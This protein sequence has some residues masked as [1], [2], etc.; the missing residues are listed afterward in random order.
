MG[1][2]LSSAKILTNVPAELSAWECMNNVL[3]QLA[4]TSVNVPVS[5][6]V[7]Q[8]L[9]NVNQTQLSTLVS[10]LTVCERHQRL[11]KKRK[12]QRPKKQSLKKQQLMQLKNQQQRL[13]KKHQ[14]P[15]KKRK[16]SRS[17][18]TTTTTKLYFLFLVQFSIVFLIRFAQN[19]HKYE[20]RANCLIDKIED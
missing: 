8:P 1:E 17:T 16:K 10:S 5:S 19:P 6:V 13:K 12:Q 18:A 11:K 7:T 4:T 3:T 14:Q 2:H 15:Q 9:V 20:R